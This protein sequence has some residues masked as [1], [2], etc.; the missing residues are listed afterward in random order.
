MPRKQ[1]HYSAVALLISGLLFMTGCTKEKNSAPVPGNGGKIEVTNITHNSVTIQWTR[2]SDDNTG[3]EF[4]DYSVVYSKSNN[5]GDLESAIS[6]GKKV[7]IYIEVPDSDKP[8]EFYWNKNIDSI[9]IKDLEDGQLY[10]FNVISRDTQWL[11]SAYQM[12]S[13]KTKDITAPVPGNAGLVETSMETKEGNKV[14]LR[15]VWTKATDNNSSGSDVLKY[16]VVYSINDVTSVQ[17]AILFDMTPYEPDVQEK[18]KWVQ[19]IDFKEISGLQ[20]GTN[21]NFNV[22]VMDEAGNKNSYAGTSQKP[23]AGNNGELFITEE[24]NTSLRLN[25]SRAT[26]GKNNQDQIEY[27]VMIFEQEFVGG[28]KVEDAE[29]F[30]ITPSEE[31]IWRKVKQN[32]N[33]LIGLKLEN[34]VLSL[35]ITGLTKAKQYFFNVI[36]KDITGF[37]V[38]YKNLTNVPKPGG[39][40]SIVEPKPT[41][42]TLSW[43]T[44]TDSGSSSGDLSYWVVISDS[45][46][47]FTL[48]GMKQNGIEKADWTRNLDKIQITGLQPDAYYYFNVAVRDLTGHEAVYTMISSSPDSRKPKEKSALNRTGMAFSVSI[49][50]VP[51][52]SALGSIGNGSEPVGVNQNMPATIDNGNGHLIVWLD[53]A[54]PAGNST[55]VDGE[56]GQWQDKSGQANHAVQAL[57][58]RRPTAGNTQSL[59]GLTSLRFEAGQE[60]HF[61]VPLGADID[62][63]DSNSAYTVILAA[64]DLSVPTGSRAFL[65]DVRDE[66]GNRS[67]LMCRNE[68]GMTTFAVRAEQEYPLQAAVQQTPFIALL[69]MGRDAKNETYCAL[70]VN[71]SLEEAKALS[72]PKNITNV[73]IGGSWGEGPAQVGSDFMTGNIDEVII[74]DRRLTVDEQ[75]L[76]QAYLQQKWGINN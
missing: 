25:W 23:Q 55:K 11:M 36:A 17:N 50:L 41:E 66:A 30:D 53:G 22:L 57:E 6:N 56:V 48:E 67:G 26:D 28:D 73:I 5:I 24:E 14:S 47:I 18:D 63:A 68:A 40:I 52:R 64:H 76:I 7:P 12:T 37:T 32:E 61:L 38:F 46:N 8:E 34:D 20:L 16:R 69:A 42:L 3:M 51:G 60:R 71:G 13:E 49:P 65:L 31:R 45:A 1:I 29:K 43:P 72:L 75:E 21:Y 62:M 44:A 27:R 54:D 9:K 58:N 70:T 35:E 15:L 4:L 10:Y 19:N 33:D 74:Y 59:N 2:S 39:G